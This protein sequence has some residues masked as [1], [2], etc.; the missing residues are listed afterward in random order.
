MKNKN[1]L[2]YSFNKW[3][4]TVNRINRFDNNSTLLKLLYDNSD[5]FEEKIHAKSTFYRGRIF[6]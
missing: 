5:L 6:N 3:K 1:D 2:I 4:N